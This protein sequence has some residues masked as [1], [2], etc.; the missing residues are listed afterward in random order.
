MVKNNMKFV[1]GIAI[2]LVV[3][4]SA[5]VVRYSL[6]KDPLTVD[7]S[8]SRTG[9]MRADD[10]DVTGAEDVLDTELISSVDGEEEPE[11]VD[12][13]GAVVTQSTEKIDNHRKKG[14]QIEASTTT[15]KASDD[16]AA[17][18]KK[19][20]AAQALDDAAEKYNAA[21]AKLDQANAALND[22]KSKKEQLQSDLNAAKQRL[23]DAKKN[24]D[25]GQANNYDRG[26]YAFFESINSGEG[27]DT[28][29]GSDYYGSVE[30]GNPDDAVS[31]DN[32]RRSIDFL[33]EANSL[34]AG[35]GKPELKVSC[36]LMAL[37]VMNNDVASNVDQGAN[38]T[39]LTENLAFGF[40]DPFR[41]WYDEERD[42]NGGDYQTL[43]SDE[44]V[45]A[46]FAVSSKNGKN[47]HNMIFARDDQDHGDLMTVSQFADMFNG[48]YD[49]AVRG[50]GF[51]AEE[52]EYARIEKAYND[53][54]QEVTDKE[55]AA[56]K[57]SSALGSA[58]TVYEQKL[59]AYQAFG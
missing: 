45:A 51:A 11:L 33:N 35:E 47:V 16:S 9:D 5:V 12:D 8:S 3:L 38:N 10:R 4:F 7:S 31:I 57:A 42:N 27:L 6:K 23:D 1:V 34:R 37:A 46:G 44:C 2:I 30:S 58:N 24:Y 40:D 56:Q 22:A 52:E 32:I 26:L 15:T 59:K 28:F 17:S 50:K 36:R 25:E 53:A 49:N 39:G 55:A 18:D 54:K 19:L 21:A 13:G 20:K 48:F 14:E 29:N 41:V 43:V